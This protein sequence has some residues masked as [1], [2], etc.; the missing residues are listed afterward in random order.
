MPGGR[1]KKSDKVKNQGEDSERTKTDMEQR[2]EETENDDDYEEE[3]NDR[4]AAIQ[5]IQ[6]IGKDIR[7][8]KT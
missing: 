6:A 2:S 3:G 7:N 5:P 8:L 4:A 1:R